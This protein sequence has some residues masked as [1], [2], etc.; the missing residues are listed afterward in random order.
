M[1]SFFNSLLLGKYPEKIRSCFPWLALA[2][3]LLPYLYAGFYFDDVY[4]SVLLGETIV[5]DISVID[6]IKEQ[7]KVWLFD[8][9]R[10]FPLGIFFGYS[11]WGVADTLVK[12]RAFQISLVIANA[13][14]FFLTLSRVYKGKHLSPLA[15]I[16][17]SVVIQFNPRWDGLSSFAPLNQLVT[18]FVFVSWWSTLNALN[19]TSTRKS[20]AWITSSLIFVA[21][22]LTTY[23]IGIVAWIGVL[24]IGGFHFRTACSTSRRLVLSQL[25]LGMLFLI[26]YTTFRLSSSAEYDGTQAGSFLLL[27]ST[28]AAQ[29]FS[30][31]PLAFLHNKI[32]TVDLNNWVFL[33][34]FFIIFSILWI[35]TLRGTTE[36]DQYSKDSRHTAH[37]STAH[38]DISM[39]KRFIPY[40]LAFLLMLVPAAIISMT[41][42]YQK[43]VTYGDPYI[44][45]YL[46]FFGVALFLA[47]LF[48]YLLLRIKFHLFFL[49]IAITL[50]ALSTWT[51]G[52]NYE[53]IKVKNKTF[54]S[55]RT[56]MERLIKKGFLSEIPPHS[57][58]IVDSP[59]MW[60][61]YGGG[62]SLCSAFFSHHALKPIHCVWIDSF[63]Q[64]PD[65]T[66]FKQTSNIYFLKRLASTPADAGVELVGGGYRIVGRLNSR[67]SSIVSKEKSNSALIYRL[68]NGFYNPESAGQA[69]FVWSKGISELLIFNF[70]K[71]FQNRK[72]SVTIQSVINQEI[73]GEIQGVEIFRIN[74]KPA[75]VDVIDVN[76]IFPPGKSVVK[77]IPYGAAIKLGEDPRIFSFRLLNLTTDQ[78]D[79]R[80]KDDK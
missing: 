29:F 24:I 27:G 41:G 16:F 61:G 23:E 49:G 17:L 51:I 6:F 67:S 13:V 56:E 76:I 45:V 52:I 39:G 59:H 78:Y 30:G 14:F 57:L 25:A 50:G 80:K 75:N 1:N 18:L 20:N 37:L 46:Q 60:E 34:S 77:L 5:R 3:T 28:F 65:L 53:R 10:F 22:S 4:N 63:V 55:P 32:L 54:F 42:R 2:L 19:T 71:S 47:L 66:Y 62:N 33:F 8:N 9:G 68:G 43:I 15:L 73:R 36:S 40:A 21:M 72:L 35:G 64:Q 44:V 69:D 79:Y 26:T 7:L 12:A 74:A 11:F 31:F 38:A 48:Q 70:S 58:L